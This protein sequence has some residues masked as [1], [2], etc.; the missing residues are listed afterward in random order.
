MLPEELL[1]APKRGFILPDTLWLRGKL[2]PLAEQLLSPERLQRQG[3]F[4]PH[5]YANIVR[6]HLERGADYTDQVWTLLM[7]QLWHTVFLEGDVFT[8]PTYTWQDLL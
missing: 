6:P 2:R 7:F 5:I 3:I 8:P 4:H 1:H